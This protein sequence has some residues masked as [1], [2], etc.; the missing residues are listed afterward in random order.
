[1]DDYHMPS[2]S[3]DGRGI[4][5][6]LDV[7]KRLEE[8]E[9][10]CCVVGGNA[11][12]YYGVPRVGEEWLLCIQTDRFEEAVAVFT[13][14]PLSDIF[15]PAPQI[16]PQVGSL[17]H[18]YPHLKR[19][20]VNFRIYLLPSSEYFVSDLD[21]SK[22][23]RSRLDVP[24]PKLEYF[25]QGLIDT[26]KWAELEALVD[27][28]DL[29]EEWGD[30]NLDLQK[31]GEIEYAKRKNEKIRASLEQFPDSIPSTLRVTP[32]DVRERYLKIV[33]NKKR[34]IDIL[35]TDKDKYL[36]RYRK[37]GSPDPRYRNR[38]M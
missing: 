7:I 2:A 31:P 36:T 29:T 17:L 1:M 19:K 34:R 25:A 6:I 35:A 27:G 15:E 21:P 38:I 16:L 9:I 22:I 20:D 32:R 10:T 5:E 28:M 24:Y 8:V 12:I 14:E 37:K 18:T 33:R 3:Y 4:L 23:E 26:Q 11:L 13:R 30:K